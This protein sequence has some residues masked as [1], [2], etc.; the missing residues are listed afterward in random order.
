MLRKAAS[1][2]LSALLV[3]P[4]LS[5]GSRPQAGGPGS[6]TGVI[7]GV[8]RLGD[9]PLSGVKLAFLDV[10]SGAV[11]RATSEGA[12]AFRAVVPA[13]E[14]VVAAEGGAGLVVSQG[15]TVVAVAQGHVASAAITLIAVPG[16]RLQ[17]AS[18]AAQ[19]ETAGAVSATTIQHDAIR[20][21]VEGEFPLIPARIDPA[22]KVAR[23]R[24]FF[25]AAPSDAFYYV[26]MT[27]SEQGFVGKLPRPK[28]EASPITYFVEG[29]STEF[30][31]ARTGPIEALVVRDKDECEGRMAAAGPPGDVTVF[32][33]ATGAAVKPI[34]FAAGG[35]LAAG[36]VLLLLAGGAAA[37]GIAVVTDVFNPTPTPSPTTAPTPTPA[38]DPPEPTPTPTPSPSPTTPPVP[39]GTPFR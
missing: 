38:P 36:G 18:R 11:S 15:P 10:G 35:L 12:G 6:G 30:G 33:A 20:C 8:V 5:A 14:Y 37:V 26:E 17:D 16:A 27:P 21:F 25:H 22:D 19:Q 2:V 9:R 34:G 4:S 7:Q 31:E 39:P 29:M 24:V 1:I 32:S 13:G 3:T 28:L 23:G